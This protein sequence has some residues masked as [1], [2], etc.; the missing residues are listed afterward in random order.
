MRGTS[1]AR[2]LRTAYGAQLR[3]WIRLELEASCL[4]NTHALLGSV[5]VRGHR[6]GQDTRSQPYCV[7]ATLPV[8]CIS[9]VY[10][11]IIDETSAK[12]T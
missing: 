2:E 1:G 8:Q 7:I 5:C 12:T 10:N 4:P 3:R 11:A 9:H 6:N